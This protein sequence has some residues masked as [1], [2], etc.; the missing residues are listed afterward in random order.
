M[1]ASKQ[2]SKHPFDGSVTSQRLQAQWERLC[3]LGD[4][5][6]RAEALLL[7]TAKGYARI[8]KVLKQA[9]ARYDRMCKQRAKDRR[10]ARR[11]EVPQ[12][13]PTETNGRDST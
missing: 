10:A 3:S 13:L 4:R 8:Q 12:P 6:E 2:K 9:W 11:R 5:K 7:K 1:K